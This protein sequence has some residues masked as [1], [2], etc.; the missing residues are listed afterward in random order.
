MSTSS[1]T[2]SSSTQGSKENTG[3]FQTSSSS[4]SAFPRH[5][6]SRGLTNLYYALLELM[7]LE[8]SQSY[9]K[10]EEIDRERI[11]TLEELLKLLEID[12]DPFGETQT[13][14]P[15]SDC[16][17]SIGVHASLFEIVSQ[18]NGSVMSFPGRYGFGHFLKS[19]TVSGTFLSPPSGQ[20][21]IFSPSYRSRPLAIRTIEQRETYSRSTF[22]TEVIVTDI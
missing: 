16:E 3:G 7:Q 6:H 17:E 1:S 19:V 11:T 22:S 2:S 14:Y 18:L 21:H 13:V 15:S 5:S 8:K 10:V 12:C 20:S 9:S 4:S